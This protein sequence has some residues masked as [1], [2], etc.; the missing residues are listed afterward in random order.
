M[1]RRAPGAKQRAELI[2]ALDVDSFAKARRLVN[3]LYPWIKIFKVGLQLYTLCG[4]KIIGFIRRKGGDVFLDLKLND[5]PNT[6]AAAAREIVRH[7]VKM[8]TVHALSGPT[9]LKEVSRACKGTGAMPVAVTLL[10]SICGHF[11]KD[12]GIKR[13]VAQEALYLAKMAKRCGL[14][15]VVCSA[16]EAKLIRKKLGRDFIIVTP[17]IRPAGSSRGDQQRITTPLEAAA[18]GSNFLVVGRP[19][20]EAPDPLAAAKKI[21]GEINHGRRY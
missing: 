11:L 16:Q 21:L 12:L 5:I 2:L 9:S 1:K 10:T 8:F 14:D 17:G 3:K 13:T 7:K 15:A 18:A 20:L 19:I 4:P 6:M